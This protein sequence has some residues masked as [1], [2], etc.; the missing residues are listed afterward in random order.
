VD[1]HAQFA[2][3]SEA[4]AGGCP[5]REQAHLSQAVSNLRGAELDDFTVRAQNRIHELGEVLD[6]HRSR[7]TLVEKAQ[8]CENDGEF[9]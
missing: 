4:L 6:N 5:V 1:D 2:V 3:K 7:F 8:N 9:R